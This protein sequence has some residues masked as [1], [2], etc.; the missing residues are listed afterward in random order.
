MGSD[1]TG[2]LATCIGVVDWLA[3][4]D[5]LEDRLSA[6]VAAASRFSLGPPPPLAAEPS[7]AVGALVVVAVA[8]V[9]VDVVY[10]LD[11]FV[12]TFDNTFNRFDDLFCFPGNLAHYV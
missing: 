3:S 7:S 8:V 1:M 11:E 4:G 12:G 10:F 6:A 5:T 2:S 9:V